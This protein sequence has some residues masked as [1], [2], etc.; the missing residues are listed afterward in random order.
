MKSFYRFN[1]MSICGLQRFI[2]RQFHTSILC[3]SKDVFHVQ[4]QADFQKEVIESK[5]LF[6]VD[7]YANW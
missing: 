1:I 4:D 2:Y 7:F 3:L 6:I 5:K